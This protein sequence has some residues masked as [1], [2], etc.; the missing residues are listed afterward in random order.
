MKT[1]ITAL[2]LST[3]AIVPVTAHAAP[4]AQ[5]HAHGHLQGHHVAATRHIYWQGTDLGTDPDPNIRI[6]IRRDAD[7]STASNR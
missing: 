1:L 6:Q 3:A 7:A 4:R 5:V 2:A